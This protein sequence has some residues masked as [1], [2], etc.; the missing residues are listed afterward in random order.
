MNNDVRRI[1]ILEPSPNL[2]MERELPCYLPPGVVTVFNRLSRPSTA[3]SKANLIGLMKSLERAAKDIAQTHPEVILY[4]CTSG[5][6]LLGAGKEADPGE[7]IMQYTGIRGITAAAAVIDALRAVEAKRIFMVTPYPDDINES[8]AVFL[9]HEGIKVVASDS[10]RC[11]TVEAMNK[12]SSEQ[13]AELVLKQ[14]QAIRNCD[15]VFISCTNLLT[16]D[17]I[18]YLEE[19]LEMPIITSNQATLWAGLRYMNVETRG[20]RAGRLFRLARP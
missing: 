14:R 5:S 4:G 3:M 18:E 7:K 15:A 19:E 9:D 13:V 2:A 10:F 17:K 6:F 8:E 12:I 20:I 16:M 1:G 11:P